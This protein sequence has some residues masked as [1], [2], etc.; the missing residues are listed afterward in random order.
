MRLSLWKSHSLTAGTL[1]IQARFTFKLIFNLTIIF[2][3]KLSSQYSKK[4]KLTNP[5]VHAKQFTAAAPNC[6]ISEYSWREF[7]QYAQ[8]QIKTHKIVCRECN[9]IKQ[10]HTEFFSLKAAQVR[11]PSDQRLLPAPI[12]QILSEGSGR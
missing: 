8:D 7:A 3:N 4:P 10:L 12:T 11:V 5:T 1:K 9:I 6:A 2:L